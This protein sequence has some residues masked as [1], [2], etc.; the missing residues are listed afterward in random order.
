MTIEQVV[1]EHSKICAYNGAG[2]KSYM[3]A[4]GP[5]QGRGAKRYRSEAFRIRQCGQ[6]LYKWCLKVETP[7]V[8]SWQDLPED[9]QP[10]QHGP[11]QKMSRCL[12]DSYRKEPA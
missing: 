8:T 3:R 4:P 10:I 7:I 6:H 9:K 1:T 2:S 11:E 12:G 5:H